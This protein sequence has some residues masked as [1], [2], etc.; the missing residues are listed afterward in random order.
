[1][2]IEILEAAQAELDQAIEYYARE[3]AGLGDE[4]LTEVLGALERIAE[5]PHAWHA[6]SKRTHRCQT[7]RF[8]YGIVYLISAERILV[9]AIAHL[10]RKPG[11]WKS[12]LDP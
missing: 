11:Y 12:R 6:Y 7:R 9:V 2:Q 5:H 3:R 4:F 1:M 10:H 8:P